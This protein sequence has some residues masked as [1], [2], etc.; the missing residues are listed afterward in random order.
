MDNKGVVIRETATQ[1]RGVFARVKI[2]KGETISSFDGTIYE[3]DYPSWNDDLYNHVI[4]FEKR[5]WRDSSGIAR[6]INHS[7]D[8]NCGIKNLFDV[9]AMRDIQ[10]GEEITWDYEMTENYKWRMNCTCGSPICRKTIGAYENMPL[11]IRKKYKGYISA[12]LSK[13]D[14]V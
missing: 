3:F 9:V 7:C 13:G 5:R 12:W 6:L 4:Q 14:R 10:P 2:K 11:A 1:G 8:P